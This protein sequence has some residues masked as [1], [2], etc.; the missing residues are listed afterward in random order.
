MGGVSHDETRSLKRSE[1]KRLVLEH[2]FEYAVFVAPE[3][4]FNSM[5]PTFEHILNS[6]RFK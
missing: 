3:P 6:I 1:W 4:D 2:L 5:Q